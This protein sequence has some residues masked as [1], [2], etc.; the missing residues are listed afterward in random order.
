MLNTSNPSPNTDTKEQ[1]IFLQERPVKIAGNQ[2]AGD[3]IC[4]NLS[5]S[6]RKPFFPTKYEYGSLDEK[7]EV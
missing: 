1:T 3:R 6:R 7:V 5:N 2:R 4:F